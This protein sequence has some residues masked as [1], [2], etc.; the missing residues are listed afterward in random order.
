MKLVKTKY[1]LLRGI[2]RNGFSTFFGVPYAKPPVG[3]LRWKPPQELEP[4]TIR[5]AF[6]FSSIP[7]QSA[8]NP[9]SADWKGINYYREFYSDAAYLPPC[10][11][12]CLYLNIWTPANTNEDRLPVAFWIHGGGF[13]GGFGSEIEFD[14]ESFARQG[15]ILVT[16]N[17]R[18]GAFGFLCHPELTKEGNGFSGNYGILDQIAALSWV[19]ENISAFGGDPDRICIFGQSAGAV[20]VQ[21]LL[22][23]PLAK[24]MF[25]SAIMQSAGGYQTGVDRDFT[26]NEA[27]K[28]GESFFHECGCSTLAQMRNL[29]PE[30]ILQVVEKYRFIPGLPSN[31]PHFHFA[32]VQNDFVMPKGYNRSI[33]MGL[34]PDIP[35]MLGSCRNEIRMTPEMVAAGKYS[36]LYYGC[37]N[38]SLKQLEHQHKPSYVYFFDRALPGSSDGAFHSSE[39]WYVFNTLGRSWRPNTPEDYALAE[40]MNSYWCNFIKSGNPNGNGLKQWDPCS[41]TDHNVMVFDIDA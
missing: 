27:E 22:S 7:W 37:I 6:D 28:C 11:E 16:I 12:D 2:E 41:W 40:K 23:S 38:W 34:I 15:V 35:Y 14:G 20:S 17:Y 21:T 24:G 4:W 18:L 10:N 30:S 33:E 5:D 13:S 39:L 3:D 26:Q 19:R 25:S 29:S 1:G 32:P 9:P 31:G 36:H 8:H